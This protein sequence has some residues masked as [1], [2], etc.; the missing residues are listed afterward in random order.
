MIGEWLDRFFKWLIGRF[1]GDE[2]L[3]LILLWITLGCV[4][5]GLSM[6]IEGF[7]YG[8]MLALIPVSVLT[9]WL[10][11]RTRW[12]GWRY[13][14]TGSLL[15]L[16]GLALTVGKIG[17]PLFAILTSFFSAAGQW[18]QSC[19]VGLSPVAGA[20]VRECAFNS[21]PVT[22]SWQ[23][24]AESFTTLLA[25]LGNWFNTLQH[26][27]LINDPLVVTFLGGLA[28]WLAA[29]W[30]LWWVRRRGNVLAG[31][32][33]AI[34]FLAYFIFQN[35]FMKAIPWLVL[36]C[37]G[38]L[39]L[40]A[41]G[42]FKQSLRRW[43]LQHLD[44]IDIEPTLIFSVT[45]LTIGMMLAGGLLP[46]I[47]VE[48]LRKALD[49]A[50]HTDE[51][52]T[53]VTGQRPITGIP[54]PAV[55]HTIGPGPDPSTAV[56]MFVSVEGYNPPPAGYTAI[57]QQ[58]AVRYYWRSQTYDLYTGYGWTTNSISVEKV[59]ANQP[60]LPGVDLS[61]SNADYLLVTQHITRFRS[62]EGVTFAAGELLQLDQPATIL[63]NDSGGFI[64]ARTESNDY[65]AVSR[66]RVASVEQLRNAGI[67]Y[68]PSILRYLQ[69]PDE[70]P[71]RVRDLS[72]SLTVD[73]STP[74]DKAAVLEAYLYQ[75]P[76]SLDVPRPPYNH[77]AVD[78]FLFDLK[79]GYCDYFASAMVV[80][81]RA[82]GLPARLVI[83][84]TS[85]VYD[86]LEGHF[87][88]RASNAHAWAQVYFPNIGW[89]D[90]D[91][92]S[93]QP[94][95]YRPG[96]KPE[97]SAAAFLPPPGQQAPFRFALQRVWAGGLLQTL[98]GIVVVAL[99]CLILPF[100]TWW[101]MLL[102]T[103]RALKAIFCRLYRRGR[104]FHIQPN[105]SRTP[106]EF[107]LALADRLNRF[108]GEEKH[109]A[110]VAVLCT[111]LNL[112]TDLYDRLLFSEYAL[113]LDE[114]REAVRTWMRLRRGLRQVRR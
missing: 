75:F 31:L 13:G 76:Y 104:A 53:T 52:Q 15:G 5:L 7:D 62:D 77:D 107:A 89:V 94:L 6:V 42:N 95:P 22:A 28:F 106:N 82:A 79:K 25:R 33:P 29:L 61:A 57:V 10:L 99:V 43:A 71:A 70:L 93:N 114:K 30:A 32:L 111:D 84:Y 16:V 74:Y 23:A 56:I 49:D 103:D 73:Q 19:V 59:G 109:A 87:V 83:G 35:H 112:L 67:D 90:F 38:I 100:E 18:F 34:A 63:Q 2:L 27:G 51:R 64:A 65:T 92:T 40:Q 21:L 24:L 37:G 39:L 91:P 78:F 26:D 80:M 3:Q 55:P 102:P 46:T 108:A 41:A 85:G 9:T 68:P 47:P 110:L 60:L 50:L 101:L 66:V 69:L 97:A 72:I 8:F 88:V 14:L 105:P 36:A 1:G 81:A 4:G 98:L 96:E 11:T 54:N 44:R 86:N 48:K 17:R 113:Q 12:P 58:S 20:R 45:I